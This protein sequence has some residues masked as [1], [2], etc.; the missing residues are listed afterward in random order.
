MAPRTHQDTYNPEFGNK[1]T[2]LLLLILAFL[3][4]LGPANN[5]DKNP[6]SVPLNTQGKAKFAEWCDVRGI[7][8]LLN[9]SN[10]VPGSAP[11]M[12]EQLVHPTFDLWVELARGVRVPVRISAQ[13]T[14]DDVA[15]VLQMLGEQ[16][17]EDSRLMWVSQEEDGGS[18]ILVV[19]VEFSEREAFGDGCTLPMQFRFNQEGFLVS[20]QLSGS[21]FRVVE[22]N[23]EI[24]FRLVP[25]N[26][27]ERADGAY[28]V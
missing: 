18:S 21:E 3:L 15:S 14:R 20:F 16:E 7:T 27:I 23:G 26:D 28:E 5:Q 10:T 9:F 24:Y 4:T 12:A 22:Y 19:R 13:M 1:N 6:F 2:G 11:H 17:G 8:Y 25:T